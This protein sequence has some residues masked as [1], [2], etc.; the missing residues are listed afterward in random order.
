MLFSVVGA[1]TLQ[2]HQQHSFLHIL[3]KQHGIS[4]NMVDIDPTII[5]TPL[6]QKWSKQTN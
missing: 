1:P 4:C 5:N 6:K 2:S 3:A